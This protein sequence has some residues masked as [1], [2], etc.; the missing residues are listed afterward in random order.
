MKTDPRR[1]TAAALRTTPRL[2]T[3]RDIW[4]QVRNVA[5]FPAPTAGVYAV[6]SMIWADK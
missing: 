1:P 3:L 4:R 2:H 5:S 6:F